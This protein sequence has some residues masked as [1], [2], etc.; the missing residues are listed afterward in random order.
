MNEKEHIKLIHNLAINWNKIYDGRFALLLG[1]FLLWKVDKKFCN[2]FGNSEQGCLI[3]SEI[4]KKQYDIAL[5]LLVKKDWISKHR[6]PYP[7]AKQKLYQPKAE[8][9]S[10]L[11]KLIER[12]LSLR[13]SFYL[14]D[15]QLTIADTSTW[16]FLILLE[17]TRCEILDSCF[18]PL[19]YESSSTIDDC[20]EKYEG[21]RK[22]ALFSS[23]RAFITKLDRLDDSF[24]EYAFLGE[25]TTELYRTAIKMSGQF[26]QFRRQY[27]NSYIKALR[28]EL[29]SKSSSE[30]SVGYVELDKFKAQLGSGRRK[31]V[32]TLPE[33][34]K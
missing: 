19:M 25:A 23:K 7:R 4:I 1:S 14:P 2:C 30:W 31:V 18:S 20:D 32:L 24:T 28:D 29:K 11:F 12:C 9:F 5:H 6:V 26:D 34:P 3:A 15:C 13:K 33:L 17:L 22:Q 16:F 8:V 10:H 21:R 27:W